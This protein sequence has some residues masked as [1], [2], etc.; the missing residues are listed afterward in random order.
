MRVW[1]RAA[2]MA[3]GPEGT[4]DAARADHPLPAV[5]LLPVV[6]HL[7]P[8][9]S[10]AHIFGLGIHHAVRS[11]FCIERGRLWQ[12]EYWISS[13]RDQGM[14]LACHRLG[15]AVILDVV[16]NHLGPAGSYLNRFGPYFTTRH[17]TPWGQAVNM[18]GPGSD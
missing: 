5:L 18:D 4:L 15:L 12:A 10:S 14:T 3:V 9:P 11:H 6:R 8:A 2:L 13:T 1:P 7:P 17:A 16:Y